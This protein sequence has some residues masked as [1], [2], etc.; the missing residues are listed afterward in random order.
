MDGRKRLNGFTYRKKAKEK[1]EKE[2]GK[3]KKSTNFLRLKSSKL[4][5]EVK[6]MVNDTYYQCCFGS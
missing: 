1:L 2:A 6:E 5:F 3:I 4:Q